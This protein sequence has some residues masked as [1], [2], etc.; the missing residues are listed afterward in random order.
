MLTLF[1]PAI[2]TIQILI[3]LIS[4]PA[5]AGDIGFINQNGVICYLTGKEIPVGPSGK[6]LIKDTYTK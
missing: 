1:K 5:F 2:K 3:V 6:I 4:C